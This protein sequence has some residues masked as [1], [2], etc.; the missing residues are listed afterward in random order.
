MVGRNYGRTYFPKTVEVFGIYQQN[1]RMCSLQCTQAVDQFIEDNAIA[2]IR[3]DYKVAIR[4]DPFQACQQGVPALFTE[5]MPFF[6]PQ[7]HN[8]LTLPQHAQLFKLSSNL[9]F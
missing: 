5:K 4:K 2:V 6:F 8:V 3:N 7:T 1:A 9:I